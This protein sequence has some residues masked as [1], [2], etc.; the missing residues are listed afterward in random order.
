VSVASLAGALVDLVTGRRPEVRNRVKF[1]LL[2]PVYDGFYLVFPASP[3]R[4]I[5]RRIPPG[6]RRVLD[7]CTG[8]ALV[9]ALVAPARPELSLVGLDL[10]PEMLAV[11]RAKLARRG[12]RNAALVRAD[13]GRLPFPDGSFD[14]VTVSYGLHELPTAVRGRALEEVRRV[15]RPQG[16]L[17]VADLDRPPRLGFLVDV[18]LRIGE[19]AHAREVLG[20]WLVALL[21]AAGFAVEAEPA[22]GVT[23]M[24]LLVGRSPGPPAATLPSRGAS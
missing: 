12:I 10:S 1:L 17:V 19:P 14:A 15:L 7:L 21:G 20:G 24:Q 11:G 18:Y 5:A 13:A 6:A 4:E 2:S 23:P 8:T 3:H 22:A 16:L 9:P